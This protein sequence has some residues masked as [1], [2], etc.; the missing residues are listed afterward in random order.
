MGYGQLAWS[1]R[2]DERVINMERTNFRY[3]TKE[4]VPDEIDFFSVDVS[5]ISVSYTHLD[6]YKRQNLF[7]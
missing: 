7:W 2:N 1:L 5:F 3:V 4:Q 6:V